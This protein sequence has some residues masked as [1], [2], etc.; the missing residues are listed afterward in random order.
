MQEES[1]SPLLRK[2]KATVV[3]ADKE[4]VNAD[5]LDSEKEEEGNISVGTSTGDSPIFTPRS[6]Q[7]DHASS[8]PIPPM[9]AETSF[10]H[11]LLFVGPLHTIDDL[12]HT[13]TLWP[14][15]WIP[16]GDVWQLPFLGHCRHVIA[17]MLK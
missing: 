16:A 6:S 3:E 5:S 2:R 10:F 17:M 14:D 7:A 4:E 11:D 13:F 9:Q 15:A 1:A 8:N 12:P